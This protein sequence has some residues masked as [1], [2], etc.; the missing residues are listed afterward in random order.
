MRLFISLLFALGT[1]LSLAESSIYRPVQR[2]ENT[3]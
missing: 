1:D 3:S 2:D